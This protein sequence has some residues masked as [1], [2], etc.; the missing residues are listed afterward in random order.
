MLGQPAELQVEGD[1][2]ADWV[3]GFVLGLPPREIVFSFPGLKALPA[4][5]SPGCS[6]A[7]KYWSALGAHFART[8]LL[9]L[10]PGPPLTAATT[11]LARVET[12]QRRRFF[13]VGASLPAQFKVLESAV[14]GSTGRF[15]DQAITQDLSA[16]GVRL[17]TSILLTVDDRLRLSVGTPKSFQRSLPP[18]LEADCRVVRIQEATRR[19]RRL[20]FVSVELL[21]DAESE[22][23]RWV[24]L[25][26]D[27]QR[28]VK[29]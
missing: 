4:A 13:R 1:D 27:L 12:V 16:G 5:F 19:S 21:F 9:R 25:T 14:Q 20:F 7:V 15:E 28:G 29:L 24:Q 6:I 11:R 3:R 23:D 8:E 22:R 18:L 26:F 10:S 17:E 2:G